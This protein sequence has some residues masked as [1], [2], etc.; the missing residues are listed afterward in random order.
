MEFRPSEKVVL[1]QD[2]AGTLIVEKKKP[3]DSGKIPS[4]VEAGKQLL[5]FR[6]FEL[7]GINLYVFR[8]SGPYLGRSY[9]QVAEADLDATVRRVAEPKPKAKTA[10]EAAKT[11]A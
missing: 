7:E 3:T 9:V 8:S 10:I 2:T 5:F 6:R 1:L 11:E 4:V